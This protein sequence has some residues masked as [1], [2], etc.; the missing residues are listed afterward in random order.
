MA[1][2]RQTVAGGPYRTRGAPTRW[3][4]FRWPSEVRLRKASIATYRLSGVRICP[5][6]T[7]SHPSV[8]LRNVAVEMHFSKS[9]AQ[10]LLSLPPELRENAISYRQA[11]FYPTPAKPLRFLTQV[12]LQS[13]RSWLTRSSRSWQPSVSARR[14][15]EI[16]SNGGMMPSTRWGRVTTPTNSAQL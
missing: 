1:R 5:P 10:I 15:Y 4:M 8:K 2:T 12:T 11:S 14:L 6:Q 9:Y 3:A 16:S 13:S 7:F